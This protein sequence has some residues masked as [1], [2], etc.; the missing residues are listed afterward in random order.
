MSAQQDGQRAITTAREVLS[1]LIAAGIRDL[2]I[3]PGSRS[4]PLAY[5][6][7]EAE[8]AGKLRVHVRIDERSAAF[9]ALGL[10]QATGAPTAI[11]A[12]SGSAIGQMLPAVMEA[13]HTGTP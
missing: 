5:A 1:A 2:V 13:N 12:T 4:A 8:A 6:A 10:T 9:M 3:S 11:A 7:A